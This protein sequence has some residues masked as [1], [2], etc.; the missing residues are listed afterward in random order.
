MAKKNKI[1]NKP[2]VSVIVPVYN[3]EKYIKKCLISIVN[4]TLR[5]LEI[6]I[7]NDKSKDKSQKIIEE[8]SKKDER[9]KVIQNKT[10]KG[11]YWCRNTGLKEAKGEFIGFV[12][13]DDW[14]NKNMF[15]ELY[16]KAK[17]TKSDITICNASKI[18]N[19]KSNKIINDELKINNKKEII[20]NYLTKKK[21][22]INVEVWNKI[23]NVSFLKRY[24]LKWY[25][26]GRNSAFYDEFFNFN[27]IY[28]SKKISYLNKV[29]YYY[30]HNPSSISN[31]FSKKRIENKRKLINLFF[32][33][34]KNKKMYNHEKDIE[35]FKI[36]SYANIILKEI[37]ITGEIKHSKSLL[38][39]ITK[40]KN[41][42]SLL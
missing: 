22:S 5:D 33:F 8:I 20:K 37:N 23:Y 10:N 7:I 35:T 39:E 30:T 21:N 4:Q 31:T 15:K 41:I 27:A 11:L 14:I 2:K 6:I 38:K 32:K 28:Y 25:D 1:E 13:S 3:A 34:I 12:D 17:T 36:K 9:I 40:S 42:S 19:G 16:E 29:M 18:Y 24:K 26:N